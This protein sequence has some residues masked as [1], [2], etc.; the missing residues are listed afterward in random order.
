NI[1]IAELAPTP[2]GYYTGGIA[3]IYCVLLAAGALS[4]TRSLPFGMM[5]GVSRRTYYLG[6][7][8]LVVILGLGYSFALAMLQVIEGATKGWGGG[9][10]FFRVPWLLAGP[11]Y[12][13][14]LTSFV[15]L[16]SFWLY[17]MWCGLVYR[18]WA[19]PGLIAFFASQ[20]LVAL[21]VVV[22]VSL[23]H[24]WADVGNFFTSLSALALTGVLAAAAAV[25]GIG[26][27][28]TLRRAT[29]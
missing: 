14:W 26:G 6:T 2:K 17:G 4:M 5:L 16:V 23:S 22:A 10:H 7:A 9:L 11:W 19:L 24:S 25:F 29:V 1:A 13:T 8:T 27:F 12:E 20:V 15:L 28:T 3:S 18:R 21:V